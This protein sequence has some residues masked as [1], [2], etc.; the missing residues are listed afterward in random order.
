MYLIKWPGTVWLQQHPATKKSDSRQDLNEEL[1]LE[2]GCKT[3]CRE[4]SM[5]T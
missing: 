3:A 4:S 2:V 1:W 5:Y